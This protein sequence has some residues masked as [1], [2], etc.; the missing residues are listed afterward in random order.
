MDVNS[1]QGLP[2]Y[3][4]A[5]DKVTKKSTDNSAASTST[6]SR[7]TVATDAAAVYE[8]SATGTAKTA[9]PDMATIEQMKADADARNAQ[10]K[11]LVEKMM[12]KQTDTNSKASMWDFLRSDKLEVDPETAAQAQADIAEDGYW[13]VTQTSDRLV[14]FAKAL[15]GNDTEYADQLIDAI[16]KGFDEA[17]SEWGDELPDISKRTLEATIEKMEAWRDGT[18]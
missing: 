14:S 15:A 11:S 9:K 6:V 2:V 8:K 5:A 7:D 16:K 3:T 4:D 12:L 10:L 17:T 1:I 13:G 18:E